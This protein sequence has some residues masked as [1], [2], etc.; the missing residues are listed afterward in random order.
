MACE[1]PPALVGILRPDDRMNDWDEKTA[2]FPPGQYQGYN[3]TMI[4]KVHPGGG[5]SQFQGSMRDWRTLWG[6]LGGRSR[7]ESSKC[8][9]FGSSIYKRRIE[10]FFSLTF[11]TCSMI[12]TRTQCRGRSDMSGPLVKILALT[13]NVTRK[14]W[15]YG[16]GGRG[17]CKVHFIYRKEVL[18]HG[19]PFEVIIYSLGFIFL[20]WEL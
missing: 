7:E 13:I 12:R 20:I 17:E 15:T 9:F 1:Q 14:P 19:A 5:L 4:H 11:P 18:N 2:R 6:G 8:G 3:E 10:V 16:M